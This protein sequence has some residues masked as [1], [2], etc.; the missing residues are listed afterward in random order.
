MNYNDSC[1][2]PGLESITGLYI[3]QMEVEKLS[4]LMEDGYTI[5][6]YETNGS[7]EA[8]R[9]NGAFG[10]NGVAVGGRLWM[11]LANDTKDFPFTYRSQTQHVTI[12]S[13]NA[14]K[15]LLYK[16]CYSEFTLGL[17]LAVSRR[18]YRFHYVN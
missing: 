9:V 15:C 8:F 17:S 14:D 6:L 4:E 16:N 10:V 18:Y 13:Q 11:A 3:T 1:P 12:Q 5:C 7:Q 2:L